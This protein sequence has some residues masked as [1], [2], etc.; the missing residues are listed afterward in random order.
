MSEYYLEAKGISKSFGGI[1]A[2]KAVDLRIRPGESV[3]LVGENGCG[4]STLIK[5]ISGVYA[6]DEGEIVIDGVA[7]EQMTPLLST[8]AGVQVIY[9]DF[10]LFHNLSVAEN[11]AMPVN[12]SARHKGLFR[13]SD[14]LRIA[15]QA[16]SEIGVPIDPRTI[17]DDLPI[18]QRQIVAICRAL[19]QDARLIIMD[20]PTTALTMKEV[21]ALYAIINSLKSRGIALLFVSH[22]MDEVFRIAERII[23]VRNG[24]NVVEGSVDDFDAS[25][26]S[27]YM[28]GKRQQIAPFDN[29]ID[30]QEVIFSCKGLRARDDTFRGVGFELYR[31]EV[32]GI[33]GL[34]GSGRESLAEALFG[35]G[36]GG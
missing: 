31:G 34:L 27:Y 36:L 24:Q 20:E 2:L 32:L 10:A 19:V 11:I 21:T 14:N 26:L 28:T 4:K 30:R 13:K 3:C 12:L 7:H 6:A 35:I 18:A 8:R 25:S 15:R 33:T 22:K 9:Q 16:L 17:V 1:Q 5:I 23:V 29:A